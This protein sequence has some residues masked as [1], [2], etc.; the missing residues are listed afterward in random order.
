MVM[1]TGPERSVENS[2]VVHFKS[3]PLDLNSLNSSCERKTET[4]DMCDG[5]A[6]HPV[7]SIDIIGSIPMSIKEPE[8]I[9]KKKM[10]TEVV[11]RKRSLKEEFEI[12]RNLGH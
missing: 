3:E 1:F 7:D 4:S 8:V 9:A 10:K 2:H 11:E 6:A 5:N 12:T